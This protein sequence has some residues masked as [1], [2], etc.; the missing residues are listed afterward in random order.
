[1]ISSPSN[2]SAARGQGTRVFVPWSLYETV[3]EWNFYPIPGDPARILDEHWCM[4]PYYTGRDNY[5]TKP[6]YPLHG[7]KI[8]LSDYQQGPLEN[9]TTGA[10]HFNGRDQY[11][12]L[13]NAD[14]E[15]PVAVEGGRGG[16]QSRTFTGAGLSNPQI[17]HSNFLIELYFMTAPGQEGAVLIQKMADAGFNLTVNQEGGVT[18]HVKSGAS[19]ASL[20]SRAAV[21]DGQW[22]HVIAEADRKSARFTIYID[23]K[24]DVGWSRPWRG[25]VARERW[26]PLCGR[27]AAGPE[28]RGGDRFSAPRA[29][30]IGRFENID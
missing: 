23:G 2:S 11:A 25:C 16:G 12:V 9:W 15:R 4:S 6:T 19:S 3:G 18:L 29:R 21:N 27:H 1:M 8:K 17:H 30:H 10:L 22:H 7:I 14:I 5:H 20:A 28:P 24:R 13:L 26:R